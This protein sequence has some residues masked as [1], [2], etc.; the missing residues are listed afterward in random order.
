MKSPREILEVDKMADLNEIK[1]AFRKK[2]LLFHPDS[3]G[4]SKEFILIR[5]AYEKLTRIKPTQRQEAKLIYHNMKKAQDWAMTNVLERKMFAGIEFE[6]LSKTFLR[7]IGRIKAGKFILRTDCNI[8]IIGDVTNPPWESHQTMINI[9]GNLEIR[10][11]ILNGAK[12]RAN[13]ILAGDITG[14]VQNKPDSIKVGVFHDHS[15]VTKLTANK[16]NVANCI[17]PIILKGKNIQTGDLRD[18][19]KIKGNFIT[20]RGNTI[21]HD[22]II[23]VGQS[24]CFTAKSVLTLSDDCIIKWNDKQLRLT[25]LKTAKYNC[26]HILRQGNEITISML[27]EIHDKRGIRKKIA[28]LFA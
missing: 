25:A 8:M 18:N 4:N 26:S 3:G 9:A 6:R 20:I 28:S 10:G 16:I 7:I 14:L 21:T 11:N 19:T 15:L 17:G 13:S 22:C 2:A 5:S 24:I 27:D 12:I 23:T 1:T